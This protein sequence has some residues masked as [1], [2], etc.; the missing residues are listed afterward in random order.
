M[1][2]DIMYTTLVLL[3]HEPN[4]MHS[5]VLFDIC[6]QLATI[7]AKNR[8]SVLCSYCH[9]GINDINDPTSRVVLCSIGIQLF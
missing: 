2:D 6:G 3:F 1:Y 8:S 4:R 7:L 5:P 9:V